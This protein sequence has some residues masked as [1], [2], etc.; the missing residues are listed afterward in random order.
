M[1]YQP[2]MKNTVSR[3]ARIN[4]V[5][6]EQFRKI[7]EV[8]KICNQVAN[9]TKRDDLSL[10]DVII[11]LSDKIDELISE[12][13]IRTNEVDTLTRQIK[14][15]VKVAKLVELENEVEILQKENRDLK[16]RFILAT[17]GKFKARERGIDI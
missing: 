12:V 6:P 14:R 11:W 3:L 10:G 5:P 13:E 15:D 16:N 8:A 7:E 17:S 9:I 4:D 1:G 2:S